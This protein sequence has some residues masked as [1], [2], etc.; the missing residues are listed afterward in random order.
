MRKL[1]ILSYAIPLLTLVIWGVLTLLQIWTGIMSS[2]TFKELTLSAVIV[3]GISVIVAIAVHG[4]ME[5][6][7][8]K[9]QGYLD[10]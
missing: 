9:K 6:A 3:I 7:E 5:N 4:Y 1:K 2:D 8:L 10:E